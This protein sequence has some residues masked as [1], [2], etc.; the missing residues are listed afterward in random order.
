MHPRKF[1]FY[2]HA[3]AGGGA[4]RVFAILASEFARR[5]H[6]VLFAVDFDAPENRGFLDQSIRLVTLPRGHAGAVVALARLLRREKPDVSLSGIGVSNLKHMIA[7]LMA[8]RHR[9]AIISFHGFFPSE[10]QFL[11]RIGNHLTP[12]LTRLCG[13]AVAVSDALADTLVRKHGASPART[14][15][16]Y[17]PV[18]PLEA[19][20]SLSREALKGRDPVILF[21]GR[22]APDKDIGTLLGAFARVTHPGARLAIVGDGPERAGFEAQAARMGHAARITFHGYQPN[23]GAAYRAARVFAL[24]SRRESFGNVVAEAL[25]HGLPVVTTASAGPS[26][27]IDHGRFGAIVPI[28]DEAAFAAALDRALADPGDPAPRIA[29]AAEFSI[30]RAAD[31]YLALAEDLIRTA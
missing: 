11:S 7:A 31:A 2:M 18:D 20:Q 8:G 6:E 14:M 23:P 21:V 30:D 4:E 27:I 5:G 28:G 9:R 24:T 17:N 15:R 1:L 12:L 22:M 25:A 26:E 3:L 29:R 16:I 19:P 13:G 10:P